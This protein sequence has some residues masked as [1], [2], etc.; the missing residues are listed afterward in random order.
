M[1]FAK[2]DIENLNIAF[3]LMDEMLI[4]SKHFDSS[5]LIVTDNKIISSKIIHSILDENYNPKTKEE[6]NIIKLYN[7]LSKNYFIQTHVKNS[8][9]EFSTGKKGD[10]CSYYLQDKIKLD[11]INLHDFLDFS[12]IYASKNNNNV[13]FTL[14]QVFMKGKDIIVKKIEEHVLKLIIGNGLILEDLDV[15]SFYDFIK[16]DEINFL[17]NQRDFFYNLMFDFYSYERGF[18][19]IYQELRKINN[20]WF[21]YESLELVAP[22]Y[23]F[24]QHKYYLFVEQMIK[25]NQVE[26]IR[27]T[28]PFYT[29]KEIP[30]LKDIKMIHS[31]NR[32]L[33]EKLTYYSNE[34]IDIVYQLEN[35]D[36]I[37]VNGVTLL[38]ETFVK[39][40]NLNKKLSWDSNLGLNSINIKLLEKIEV[41]INTFDIKPKELIDKGIR[42][43]FYNNISFGDFITYV[44]D[45][46]NLCEIFSIKL[47]KK[48]PKDIIKK[49]D[50][51]VKK[52]MELNEKI[53]E[54]TFQVVIEENKKLIRDYKNSDYMIKVPETI[55][56]LIEEGFELNHC[57]GSYTCSIIKKTSKIFFIRKKSNPNISFV[58][59]ELDKNNQ[60]I[61][62]K[63][64]SNKLPQKEVIKFIDNWVAEIGG[65][66]N[67]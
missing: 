37:G 35:N 22:Y 17:M 64:F 65:N 19:D 2:G 18:F 34:F 25:T 24:V 31:K 67:E 58:T 51:L 52:E 33:L 7:N 23:W 60:L 32:N 8:M 29:N 45:Y 44:Y 4:L 50:I 40:K 41:I 14:Y 36:K 30:D 47:E 39:L 54:E 1:L 10:N 15:T 42:E 46:I 3:S 55:S 9:I 6:S 16:K 62:A 26:K 5:T 43:M 13:I 21:I 27:E 11:N 28:N 38:F 53:V 61:Q 57:V 63:G 49:H 59:V 20:N 48:L 12:F 66:K 56:D